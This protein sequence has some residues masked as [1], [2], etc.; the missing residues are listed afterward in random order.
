[1]PTYNDKTSLQPT[2]R[3][4]VRVVLAEDEADYLMSLAANVSNPTA[5]SAY[6]KLSKA[7]R[8][9]ERVVRTAKKDNIQNNG[10]C[11]VVIADFIYDA[12]TCGVI[13]TNQVVNPST[14]KKVFI[15][16]EHYTEW[17]RLNKD[18]LSI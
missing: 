4:L 2:G 14:Q 3:K 18:K 7:K 1:M 11:E 16:D 15:C 5:Y 9:D 17:L 10:P 13:G 8:Y 12:Q 6:S